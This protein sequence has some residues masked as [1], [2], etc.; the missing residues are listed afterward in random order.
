MGPAHIIVGNSE[1]IHAVAVA[2][3][4]ERAG[5]CV[6]LWDGIGVSDSS[7]VTHFPTSAGSDLRMGKERIND[8]RSLWFR[9]PVPYQPLA[10]LDPVS[11]KF[12]R[13]ELQSAHGSLAA[14][15]R[16][17]AS[18]IVGDWH[19]IDAGMKGL[20]LDAAVACGFHIPDTVITNDPAVVADFRARQENLLVKHFTPH[21]WSS[22][23][24][25][26]CWQCGPVVIPQDRKIDDA[27]IRACPAIY[28]TLVNKAFD[29]RITVIGHRIFSARIVGHNGTALLDWRPSSVK[30]GELR[31]DWYDVDA[32]TRTSINALMEKLDLRYGC[33]DLAV[34]LQGNVFFFEVNTGGQFLF[35]DDHIPEMNLLG[36]MAG[37]LLAGS[38]DYQA[39]PWDVANLPDFES[40]D[41]YVE[42]RAATQRFRQNDRV[43]TRIDQDMVAI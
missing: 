22:E 31:M 29:L 24:N 7:V 4:L 26:K 27:S 3:A 37:L 19:P 34:D 28:Q 35:I 39:L 33:I 32:R 12:T 30:P 6:V 21:F 38:S 15:L 43:I 13:N 14:A 18:F 10:G 5:A 16:S 11:L 41:R 9:R 8:V 2:W 40:S 23:Q 20:Q 36:E 1:D 17:K 25:R 42:F